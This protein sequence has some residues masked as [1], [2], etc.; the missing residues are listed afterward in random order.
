MITSCASLIVGAATRNCGKTTFICHLLSRFSE[1]EPVAVKVK[2]LYPG[3][4]VHH[5][6]GRNLPAAW[7]LREE[8][9]ENGLE[10][11][12]RLLGSG[13]WRVFY[14]KVWH[15]HLAEALKTLMDQIP[16]GHPVIFESNSVR[17]VL[18]PAAFLMIVYQDSTEMKPSASRLL[19]LADQLIVTDGAKHR[20]APS[21][22][23]IKWAD[24]RFILS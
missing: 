9:I 16:A 20:P 7:E 8:G 21:E 17:E 24:Q 12:R 23:P 10:D 11:S 15:D 3:D 18:Q 22:L 13:A 4:Q 19:H 1:H 6:R 5:G 14:L 2:T